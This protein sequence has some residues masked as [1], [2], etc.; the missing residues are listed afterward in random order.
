[1]YAAVARR[2]AKSR[3]RSSLKKAGQI[4]RKKIS[5]FNIRKAAAIIIV[6]VFI[7]I[8]SFKIFGPII[9]YFKSKKDL[10][11][12]KVNKKN[13]SYDDSTFANMVNT[14]QS[15]MNRTGTQEVVIMETLMD[16]NNQDDWLYLQKKFGIREK[17]NP[18][19]YSD[20]K[21]NLKDWLDDE[22]SESDIQII[23]N[24]IFKLK[25]IKY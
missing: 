7:I 24:K 6:I 19:P 1:M 12:L 22:L 20:L 9:K 23:R 11:K 10:D 21:G 4:I 5:E 13:L 14:L 16:L 8:I 3:A 25:G 18:W 2:I 17:T 15:A